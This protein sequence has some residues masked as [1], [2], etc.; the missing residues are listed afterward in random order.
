MQ[1]VFYFSDDLKSTAVNPS[2]FSNR[3]N[4][5]NLLQPAPSPVG[6][7]WGEGIPAAIFP[8]HFIRPNTSLAACCP[9]SNSLPRERERGCCWDEGFCKENRLCRL[10][11]AF[12]TAFINAQFS[13]LVPYNFQKS[14][15]N[16][17]SATVQTAFP[18]PA[19]RAGF[20]PVHRL[21]A[22]KFRGSKNA[23]R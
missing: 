23:A 20:P 18:I 22:A 17:S 16:Q 12:Q 10:L 3:Q 14:N 7:G 2:C 4:S 19:T 1:A 11:F 8:Q 13:R 15:Q 21:S 5:Q 9:L 6:E